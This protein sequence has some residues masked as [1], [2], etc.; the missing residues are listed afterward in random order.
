MKRVQIYFMETFISLLFYTHLIYV[1]IPIILLIMF[2][3][4][5]SDEF[6]MGICYIFIIVLFLLFTYFYVYHLTYTLY[7]TRID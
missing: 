5:V 6:I 3:L 2:L 1:H 4:H 7:N